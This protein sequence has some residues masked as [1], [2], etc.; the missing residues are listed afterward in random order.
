ME[1]G[2]DQESVQSSTTPDQG[3]HMGKWQKHKKTSY[4]RQPRGQP[5]P[6]RWPQ[7]YKEQKDTMTWNTNNKK[8]PKKKHRLG[9]ISKKITG[10]LKH[11]WRN[12]FLFQPY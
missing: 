6:S 7:G 11:V 4:T 2:K 1:A 5:F 10:G 8:D 12:H 9:M 3:N